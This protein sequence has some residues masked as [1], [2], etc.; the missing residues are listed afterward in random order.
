MI[1][2]KIGRKHSRHNRDTVLNFAGGTEGNNEK[3]QDS[4]YSVRDSNCPNTTEELPLRELSLW[5]II[6]QEVALVNA[7]SVTGNNLFTVFLFWGLIIGRN[8]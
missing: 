5:S 4:R 3:H 2:K 6:F 8:I 1:W 7:R